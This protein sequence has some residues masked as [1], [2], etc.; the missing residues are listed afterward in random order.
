MTSSTHPK[1]GTKPQGK[2]PPE[3]LDWLISLRGQLGNHPTKIAKTM[4]LD[5]NTVSGKLNRLN[6]YKSPD[7]LKARVKPSLPIVRK[8]ALV[9]GKE[10]GLVEPWSEYRKRMI[11]AR[12]FLH[13]HRQNTLIAGYI[14]WRALQDPWSPD[15]QLRHLSRTLAPYLK[16]FPL[17]TSSS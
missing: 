9:P 14:A 6:G 15:L 4:G 16:D 10:S 1:P 2:W 12:L 7:Q 8:P 11:E 3:W 13:A 17:C 5:K